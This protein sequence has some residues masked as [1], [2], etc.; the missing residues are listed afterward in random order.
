VNEETVA[1]W[2]LSRQKQTNKDAVDVGVIS[3][4]VPENMNLYV[5]LGKE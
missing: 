1:H 3:K 5:E 2:G 4:P